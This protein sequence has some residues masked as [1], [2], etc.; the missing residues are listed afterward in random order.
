M[1]SARVGRESAQLVI[2]AK[3]PM[4][5][6]AASTQFVITAKG[7]A[8]I[9]VASVQTVLTEFPAGTQP[10]FGASLIRES[11]E[12][13]LPGG[14]DWPFWLRS[15]DLEGLAEGANVS[16]WENRGTD[17][18]T[19]DASSGAGTGPNLYHA[20]IGGFPSLFYQA[21]GFTLRSNWSAGQR[22][23]S[24]FMVIYPDTVL[25][26]HQCLLVAESGANRH[27]RI[28][29]GGAGPNAPMELDRQATTVRAVSGAAVTTSPQVVG[30][31]DTAAGVITFFRNGV[32]VG[33]GTHATAYA[34]TVVTRI[35]AP[36]VSGAPAFTGQLS[37]VL[38]IPEALSN[39][40]AAA[41]CGDLMARYGIS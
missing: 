4:R 21:G 8:R 31:T 1:G 2:T 6:G 41:V 29:D 7:P 40:Q 15:E 39:A 3:G 36:S 25:D 37:E 18:D 20:G 16:T 38:G 17:G 33:T 32:V 22:P 24:E 30:Y 14:I 11:G 12:D 13:P 34:G 9:G 23:V 26:G 35:G 28:N 27:W 19:L 10:R 5:L